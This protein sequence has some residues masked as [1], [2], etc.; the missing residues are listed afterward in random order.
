MLD[1]VNRPEATQAG[2]V[3]FVGGDGGIVPPSPLLE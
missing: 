1:K 2:G 3:W